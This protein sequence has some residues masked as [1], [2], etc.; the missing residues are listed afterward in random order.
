[1]T[2]LAPKILILKDS[3]RLSKV[4]NSDVNFDKAIKLFTEMEAP[5]QVE[6]RKIQN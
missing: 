1:M 3:D 2:R 4:E 5:K 6:K